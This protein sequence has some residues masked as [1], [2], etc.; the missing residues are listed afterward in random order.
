MSKINFDDKY[1]V[2]NIDQS[3]NVIQSSL[4]MDKICNYCAYKNTKLAAFGLAL[5]ICF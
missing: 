2:G 1:V 4:D 5:Q 3:I